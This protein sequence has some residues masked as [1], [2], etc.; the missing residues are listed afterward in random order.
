MS[1]GASILCVYVHAVMALLPIASLPMN[2]S[3]ALLGESS[4]I[5]MQQ[6]SVYGTVDDEETLSMK[7]L[8]MDCWKESFEYGRP[9]A[10][11]LLF[12]H[13]L[14]TGDFGMELVCQLHTQMRHFSM[15]ANFYW[16]F[17][18]HL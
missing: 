17:Y 4:T 14:I 9:S 6:V 1:T 11:S 12:L 3:P 13:R 10:G 8:P 16:H 2:E 5:T 7:S 18:W 15:I